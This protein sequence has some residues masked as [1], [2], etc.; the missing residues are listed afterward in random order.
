MESL[1]SNTLY[2]KKIKLNV[3]CYSQVHHINISFADTNPLLLFKL[4]DSSFQS[5]Q[6]HFQVMSLDLQKSE[7]SKKVSFIISDLLLHTLQTPFRLIFVCKN[8]TFFC[9]KNDLLEKCNV[10][11]ELEELYDD[12]MI[13]D[14]LFCQSQ[15]SLYSNPLYYFLT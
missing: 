12:Q 13:K 2:S 7:L 3:K 4:I 1:K 15:S 8:S 14:N 9:Y 6:N 5:Q 10:T 11:F